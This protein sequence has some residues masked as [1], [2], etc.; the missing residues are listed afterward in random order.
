MRPPPD[1]VPGIRKRLLGLLILPALVILIAGTVLDYVTSIN[2]VDEA[3]DQQLVD[4]ALAIAGHVR[5][6]PAGGATL[7]LPND[8][9][10]ILRADS[11]DTVYFHVAS[12]DGRFIAG[13]AGLP[14]SR[15]AGSNPS[16]GTGEY[17]GAPIRMVTYR[18]NIAGAGPVAVTMA[19]TLH[20]RA[21][22][23]TRTLTRELATDLVQLLAV[24][25]ILWF[26]VRLALE[27]L[28]QVR[29]QIARRSARALEPLPLESVPVEIRSIVEALN[30]LFATVRE[31]SVAQ[32]GF[33]ES[34]AHQ[35]RTPL[36]GIQA[37]LELMAADEPDVV[38]RERV[39][40]ILEGARRLTH[41]TQQ[42][43]TLARSDEATNLRWG[44]AEV[45]LAQTA[46]GVVA[47]RLAAADLVGV[48]LGAQLKS[49]RF[50]GVEWLLTEALG[51][52]V[53]NAIAHTPAGGTVT[54]I[55]GMA[56]GAPYLEVL[57]T[58]VGIPVEE[59]EQVLE[60][61]Y[62]ASN[63]RGMGTGLG[64]AIVMEVAQLHGAKVTIDAGPESL[65]TVVRMQFK[66]P[67]RPPA[68]VAELATG[69]MS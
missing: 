43:L 31:S 69:E 36:A 2:P 66:A 39:L 64:L 19:E 38:R 54:V 3:Y 50:S 20:K 18:T 30:R 34:A 46:E 57:D 23:R 67:G 24:G 40:L 6:D 44:F 14:E 68:A 42:L 5:A 58:G 13:D 41:T 12:L 62:R 55:S 60:R 65:G 25:V 59:R 28:G 16:R 47:D 11:Y 45:D 52:L 33:L 49:A 21:L 1:Q 61:F 4:G 7:E 35:L 10:S 22:T 51:N 29:E 48:D 37:Q 26:G 17:R 15:D 56:G 27:P 8:A 63:A 53:N 9:V 32:R